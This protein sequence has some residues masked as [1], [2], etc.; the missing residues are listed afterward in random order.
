MAK[1]YGSKIDQITIKTSDNSMFAVRYAHPNFASQNF[2][3]TRDV[4]Q[5]YKVLE[6]LKEGSFIRNKSDNISKFGG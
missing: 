6:V 2:A 5:D 4:I 3:N 1:F